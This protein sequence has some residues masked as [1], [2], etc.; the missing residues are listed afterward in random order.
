[1]SAILRAASIWNVSFPVS[2]AKRTLLPSTWVK[3]A[4]G[5]MALCDVGRG[6]MWNPLKSKSLAVSNGT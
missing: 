6:V 4:F 2:V 5:S 3:N 1:M